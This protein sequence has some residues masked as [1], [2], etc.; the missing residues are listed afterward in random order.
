MLKASETEDCH[1]P[2]PVFKLTQAAAC[3]KPVGHP[4]SFCRAP[5]GVA[6]KETVSGDGGNK[7]E[8]TAVLVNDNGE[9]VPGQGRE[10]ERRGLCLEIYRRLIP[11][12]TAGA[13][14]LLG[15]LQGGPGGDSPR[16]SEL[17]VWRVRNQ[18][19][20]VHA[21]VVVGL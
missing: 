3:V 1:E 20:R 21:L 17:R 7:G 6:E 11:L 12:D 15:G 19:L 14:D 18:G 4:P 2:Y 16:G 9:L 13:R 5:H 10:V 8:V